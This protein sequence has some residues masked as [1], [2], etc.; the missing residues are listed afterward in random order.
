MAEQ[1]THSTKHWWKSKIV[2]F[3][4]IIAIGAA[5]EASLHVIADNFSPEVYFG[6]ILGITSVNVILRFATSTSIGK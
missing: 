2:W 4:V 6:L 3:N 1:L 5:A